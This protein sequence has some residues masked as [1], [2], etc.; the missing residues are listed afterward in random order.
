MTEISAV[1]HGNGNVS[2][3]CF[4]RETPAAQTGSMAIHVARGADEWA[5]VISE[6]FVPLSL[7]TMSGAVTGSVRSSALG[8][9]VTL[10]AV[11]VQGQSVAARTSRLVRTEP[12]DDFLFSLHLDGDGAVVQDGHEA[13]LARGGGVL[14]DSARPYQL[15]FPTSHR[16]LVLQI[17]RH[18]LSDRVGRVAEV[19]GRALPPAGPGV[20]VLAACVRELAETCESLTSTPRAELGVTTVDLLATVLRAALGHDVGPRGLPGRAA[21]LA[22][23]RTYVRDHLSDPRLSLT[24]LARCH[25]VSVRYTSELFAAEDSSPAAFIRAERLR[26][27]RRLLADPRYSA[28][29]VSTVAT[30]CGFADRTTF[31]RAFVRAYGLPPVAL[32]AAHGDQSE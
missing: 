18:Q 1:L 25:G 5:R 13:V 22:S 31:T 12:R 30:R 17:P 9:A 2:T 6:S 23:M 7:V 14:Y 28:L 24:E 32:R 21:L 8:P 29:T 27:A 19:C 15:I 16:Q 4:T 26:A 10:S 3:D 20:R 11:R